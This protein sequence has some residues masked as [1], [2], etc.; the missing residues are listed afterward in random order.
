MRLT[1]FGATGR[2]GVQLV[3]QALD[4]GHQVTGVVRDPAGLTVRHPRLS[5]RTADITDPAALRPT[6]RGADAA[7]SL[8]G[9]HGRAASDVTSSGVRAILAALSDEGVRRFVAVSAAPVAPPAP[10][11]TPL[12]RLLVNP[13][14]SS[15]FREVHLDLT[16]ME[17]LI[18]ASGTDWT[19]VRPP[20]LIDRPRRGGVRREIGGNV[21]RGHVLGRAD[22]AATLLACL[23]DPAT[24]G[25]A[26]GV[27]Y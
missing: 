20:R 18:R 24:V 1:V 27:A 10:G 23:D 3:Q 4:A 6:V 8:L 5:V 22:L 9:P 13:L 19:V 7:I 12:Y 25:Q 2:T 15:V 14:V 21:R 17:E 26:V 16:R 11:E